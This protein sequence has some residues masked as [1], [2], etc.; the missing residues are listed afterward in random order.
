L[1]GGQEAAT[2]LRLLLL[3]LPA[4]R[5]DDCPRSERA[6][7]DG[8]AGSPP[9]NIRFTNLCF[10]W[11]LFRF[12]SFFF[13]GS[14]F[15]FLVIVNSRPYYSDPQKLDVLFDVV[16]DLHLIGFIMV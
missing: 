3:L 10:Q 1:V 6:R 16:L 5:D 9:N 4:T 11:F 2:A 14:D 8:R 13:C 12:F 7:D 15:F